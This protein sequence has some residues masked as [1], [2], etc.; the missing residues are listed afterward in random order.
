MNAS[1]LT[2]Y[3]T[4][5]MTPGSV[6]VTNCSGATIVL[7]ECQ[8]IRLHDSEDLTC[9]VEQNASSVGA[10]LEG[11]ARIVFSISPSSLSDEQRHQPLLLD[12]KDFNW[13]RNGIPSPNFRVVVE[14]PPLPPGYGK[15]VP[16]G[17]MIQPPIQEQTNKAEPS[18]RTSEIDGKQNQKDASDMPSHAYKVRGE[19]IAG[20]YNKHNGDEIDDEDDEL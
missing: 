8:Q 18:L 12:A 3:V 17:S 16:Q 10:I 13:L 20:D 15:E 19:P 9:H 5:A 1:N 4:Q 2:I 6:H 11:C 14:E 7:V